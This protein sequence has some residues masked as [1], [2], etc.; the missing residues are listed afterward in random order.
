MR[1][2]GAKKQKG[3]DQKLDQALLVQ[4]TYLSKFD[5]VSIIVQENGEINTIARQRSNTYSVIV[6]F[7]CFYR[8]KR[9]YQPRQCTNLKDRWS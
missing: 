4:S 2:E 7:S 3:L 6:V 8:I 5:N 9:T 1:L